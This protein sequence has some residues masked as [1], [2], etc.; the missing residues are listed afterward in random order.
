[1]LSRGGKGAELLED[2]NAL[3]SVA[4]INAKR[5]SS[6]EELTRVASSMFVALFE[7]LFHVR[8][9]GI[10]RNPYTSMDYTINAQLVVDGLAGQIDMDL[11]H[12]D[13][14]SIVKGDVRSISNLVHIFCRC[15]KI[16]T[17]SKKGYGGFSK[18][19]S[20]DVS[21]SISTHDSTFITPPMISS[22]N[23]PFLTSMDEM[24]IIDNV[25]R[26]ESAKALQLARKRLS[27]E[28]K[29]EAAKIRRDKFQYSK[30]LRA[31]SLNNQSWRTT[32]R[33]RQH[34]WQE[35]NAREHDAFLA[36]KANEEQVMLKRVYKAIIKQLHELRVHDDSDFR[37]KVHILRDEAKNHLDSLKVVFDNKIRE[38]KSQRKLSSS[39]DDRFVR[40]FRE[41][42][43]SLEKSASEKHELRIKSVKNRNDQLRQKQ[44]RNR[45]ELHKALIATL[46]A[47][48][49]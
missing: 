25:F 32:L 15:A 49:F 11:Q 47:E 12:I 28:A 1:M 6:I 3:L 45:V 27:L 35:E 36:R 22:R 44:L 43:N 37:H 8:L 41:M 46:S 40:S 38:L 9:E 20:L 34:R 7:S 19:L 18:D 39:G 23:K 10:V 2:V 29:L 24:D 42:K 16:A 17:R 33:V 4:G 5:I 14:Q 31:K 13:G 30:E 26:E 21:G 48:Y